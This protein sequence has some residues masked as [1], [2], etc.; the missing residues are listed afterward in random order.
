M[1][2]KS[3]VEALLPQTQCQRCEYAGCSP[4]AEAITRGEAP[5]NKCAPGG[6]WVLEK[7]ARLE[8]RNPTKEEVNG[9]APER[10]WK[11]Y[12]DPNRCIGCYKCVEVCPTAAIVGQNKSLHGVLDD[13]CTGCGLC[14]PTCPMDCIEER[15]SHETL[16]GR[17]E[18]KDFFKK[19]YEEKQKR[20]LD[21]EAELK[22][23]QTRLRQNKPT[24][25]ATMA[26]RKELFQQWISDE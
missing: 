21:K 8:G 15:D 25:E 1:P 20:Q 4:Y 6:E 16:N 22:K 13:L 3:Q 17:W 2:T 26:A 19:A 12:I 9:L 23:T 24:R 10:M 14:L 11:A 7:L 18:R 5:L